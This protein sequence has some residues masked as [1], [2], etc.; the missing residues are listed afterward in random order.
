M[1]IGFKTSPNNVSWQTLDETWAAAGEMDV[2]DSAWMNDHLSFPGQERWGSA[3][4]GFTMTAALAHRVPGKWVGHLVLSNTFRHPAVLAKQATAM[5]HV[6]GG[7]FILGLGAGWHEGEHDAFGVPLPPLGERFDRF[8]SAVRVIKALGSDQAREQP[9]VDL[10]VPFYPLRQATND[11]PPVTPGG[12]PLWLGGQKRRGLRIAAQYA[13]GWNF[14][15]SAIPATNDQPYDEFIRRRDALFKA[16]EEV[17]RDPSEL[18]IS[19]QLRAG[20]TPAERRAS[21]T[22]ARR[23]A[24]AGCGHLILVMNSAA[25][26]A[27]LVALANEVAEPVRELVTQRA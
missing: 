2:F 4:E 8:E 27:G 15:A 1:K 12:P 7:R 17:G 24:G 22:E 9:G 13:D 25:G 19:V 20:D 6:T 26:P 16:C 3:F 14:P 18:M 5:D 11:P 23:Y 21:V 10:D